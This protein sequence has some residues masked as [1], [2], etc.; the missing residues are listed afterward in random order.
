MRLRTTISGNLLIVVTCLAAL[1]GCSMS[2]KTVVTLD[3]YQVGGTTL[4]QID[5][6]IKDKGP[7]INGSDH[8]VAVA[9]I[10]MTPDVSFI[11]TPNGCAVKRA[12]IKVRATVVLPRWKNRKNAGKKLGQTWDNL[13]RYTK[14]HEA[15]HVAIADK[16]ARRLEKDLE[17]ISTRRTCEEAGKL[18]KKTIAKAMKKHEREQSIFDASEKKRFSGLAKHRKSS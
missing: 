4:A 13:D 8:A 7:K 1:G 15:T 3:Y 5:Q 2:S 9:N 12:R 10:K 17:A 14:L 6:E 18:T 11:S 16:H